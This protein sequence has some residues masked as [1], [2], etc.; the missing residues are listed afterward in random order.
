MRKHTRQQ[1][2][3]RKTR[4]SEEARFQDHWLELQSR[5]KKAAAAFLGL[6]AAFFLV[7]DRVLAV[8]QRDVGIQMHGLHP[9]EV[10]NVRIEIALVLGVVAALPFIGYQLLKFMK[11]GLTKREYSVMQKSLPFAYLLLVIG[12]LFA[13]I[14]IYKNALDFFFTFTQGSGTAVVWSLQRVVSF[15]L[16][17][18]LITGIL[19]QTPVIIL[20]LEK[21]GLITRKQLKQYR[22]YVLVSILF[23]AAAATPPDVLT[24]VAIALPIML[25][26]ESSIHLSRY[27]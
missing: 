20:A 14:V 8:M 23:I 3:S 13:Y 22:P 21:S 1:R 26:Y 25:L 2:K 6:T 17:I 27:T 15:G 5:L 19:F 10:L 11:P 9:L 12:S 18:S 7:S 16:R 24:Q 4:R